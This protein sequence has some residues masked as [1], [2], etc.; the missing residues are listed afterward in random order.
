MTFTVTVLSLN[1][2]PDGRWLVVTISGFDGAPMALLG[3]GP[4]PY[5]ALQHVFMCAK[6]YTAATAAVRN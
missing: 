3:T 4:T 2:L 6:V 1:P 5:G